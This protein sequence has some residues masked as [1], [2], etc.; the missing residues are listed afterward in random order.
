MKVRH[1]ISK[2]ASVAVAVVLFAMLWGW[3][4]AAGWAGE[5]PA[6]QPIEQAAVDPAMQA[7]PPQVPVQ[8]A[9]TPETIVRRVVIV[10]RLNPDG[11][12]T[13]QAVTEPVAPP[14]TTN[15][16]PAPAPSNSSAPQQPS[17]S[18]AP[19]APSAAAPPKQSAP[20]TQ[21]KPVTKSKGS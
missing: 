11:S 12:V 18:S 17:T 7:P 1:I 6:D 14:A 13:D 2:A 9:P 15:A 3:I 19:Q 5:Q 10:R 8:A 20:N 21:S 4:A 16:A